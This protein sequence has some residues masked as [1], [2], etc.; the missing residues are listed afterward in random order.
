MD[1]IKLPDLGFTWDE[2][3]VML[4][5]TGLDFAINLLTALAIF[6]IGRI[7]VKL[8]TRGMRKIMEQQDVVISS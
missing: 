3:V 5:T 6:F 7:I 1:E 8:L 2:I 4:K